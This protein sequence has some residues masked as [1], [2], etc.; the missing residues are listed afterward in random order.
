MWYDVVMIKEEIKNL[1]SVDEHA[2]EENQISSRIMTNLDD[3][4]LQSSV[5]ETSITAEVFNIYKKFVAMKQDAPEGMK[6][7]LFLAMRNYIKERASVGAY[8]D[9]LFMYRFLLV[10]SKLS[11]AS[12]HEI[13]EILTN[14]GQYELGLDFIK[15]YEQ[16]ETNKPLRLLTMANFY[17][18]HMKDYRTAIKYYEQYLKIDDWY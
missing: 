18:L 6:N 2:I 7:E 4:I 9:A 5:S 13:A 16:F 8:L 1:L 15:L 11:S 14:L 17:N 10:K 3:F 12:Y